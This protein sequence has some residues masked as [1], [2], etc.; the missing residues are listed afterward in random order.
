MALYGED[1]ECDLYSSDSCLDGSCRPYG[2]FEELTGIACVEQLSEVESLPLGAPCSHACG[3]LLG[4]DGCPAGGL[5]DPFADDTTCLGFCEFDTPQACSAGSS[6]FSYA[7]GDDDFGLCRPGCNPAGVFSGCTA[8]QTCLPGDMGLFSCFPAPMNAG[9]GAPCG[10][11]NDCAPGLACANGD[12]C[13]NDGS[14]CS[15]FCSVALED[16][17]DGLPCVDIGLGVGICGIP[18]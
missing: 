2:T 6:C 4:A 10:F 17:P 11:T 7:A 8:G 9:A 5:C 12:H 13:D 1:G 3:G 18:K 15:P 14:C 16:C